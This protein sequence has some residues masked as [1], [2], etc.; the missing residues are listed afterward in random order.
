ML[1]SESAFTIRFEIGQL[2]REKLL[3][4]HNKRLALF[5]YM[6]ISELAFT[7]RFEIGQLRKGRRNQCKS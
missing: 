6:L 4:E 7:I 3:F 2:F 1:I 5:F